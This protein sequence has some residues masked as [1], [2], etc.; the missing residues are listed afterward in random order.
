MSAETRHP[1][2]NFGDSD[3]ETH[4]MAESVVFGF[5]VFLMSDAVLFALLLAT[6][7]VMQAG[8]AGGPE[9]RDVFDLKT[10]FIE[11]MLLLASSFT[12]GM[13][14]LAT[15]YQK[16]RATMLLWLGLTLAF[17]AAFIGMEIRDF[18]TMS[19]MGA[20]Y[21]RS[22]FLSAFYTLVSAHGLHVLI[23]CIWILVV[24]AQVF[25]IGIDSALKISIL[26]LGLFWHFL[27]IVWVAIFSV[28]YLQGSLT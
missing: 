4:N 11:T 27:D 21:D 18:A 13:V 6:Y 26:R 12:F 28:V 20:R 25:A 17:G 2:L 9:P 3:A 1:G 16:S 5:W 10:T 24:V 14:S 22:G 8:T 23:G 15:K 19:S 7:G